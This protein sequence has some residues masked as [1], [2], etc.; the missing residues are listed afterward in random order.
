MKERTNVCSC[1]LTWTVSW[2]QELLD[3]ASKYAHL[4]EAPFRQPVT[5]LRLTEYLFLSLVSESP[6]LLFTRKC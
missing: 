6:V 2:Y 5:D 4:P 1:V 3:C